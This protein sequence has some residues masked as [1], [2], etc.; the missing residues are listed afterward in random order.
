MRIRDFHR[1][2][3]IRMAV[4]LAFGTAQFTTFPFMAV[5]FDHYFGMGMTGMLLAISMIA[6]LFSGAVGGFYADRVGRKRLMVLSEA[7]F[8]I[9]YLAM[10]AGNSP[11]LESPLLTF[12]AFLV[13]NVCWGMYGPADEAM[14][15]DV[16]TA[17][18]RPMMY[19][20]FYWLTNLTIAVGASI[21]ALFFEAYRF[22]LFAIM[23]IVVLGSLLVTIFFIKETHHPAPNSHDTSQHFIWAMAHNYLAILKDKTFMY[24]FLAGTLVMSVEFQLTNGIAIHLANTV[25]RQ[26]LWVIS[27]H[28][29]IVDGVKM[30]GFL[31]T[32]NTVLVVLLAALAARWIKRFPE[33]WVLFFAITLNVT[34]Y[35]VM[36]FTNMPMVL[37]IVMLLA[38]IGEVAGVPVRQAYLGDITPDHA[39]SSYVAVNG[40][41]FGLSRVLSSG[42]VALSALVPAWGMGVVSFGVGMLGLFFYFAVIPEVHARRR[43]TVHSEA[44]Q[45]TT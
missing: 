13:N 20:I 39:R 15:L 3:K 35:S 30:L 9:S 23:S 24:Y 25:K 26:V 8:L 4:Y 28:S 21:G 27:G 31:Q 41:A 5:Y 37:F 29:F 1:N 33:K 43:L 44:E 17:E 40:M 45:L 42:G 38:T 22:Q 14:L 36:T 10:A 34:G 6:S 11:W 12:I 32:E 19:A 2:I 16:T 18:N 7:I